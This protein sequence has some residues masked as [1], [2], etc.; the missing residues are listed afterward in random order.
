MI[1]LTDVAE[2]AGVSPATASLALNNSNKVKKETYERV[3]KI[4]KELNYVPNARA[5]ALVKQATKTIGLVIPE[6]INP[7]FA[8]L[9]QAIKNEVKK[10]NYNVILCSTEY[11]FEEEIKYINMF[12]KGQVDGAIFASLGEELSKDNGVI[13]EL[14]DN[15]IPVV[16]IDNGIQNHG[17]I[18]VIKSDLE[19]ASYVAARHLIELGYRDI[20][21]IGKSIKR[22]NGFR[23]AM[24][25]KSLTIN[26]SNIFYNVQDGFKAGNSLLEYNNLPEALI[27]YNDEV[28]IGVIQVLASSGINIPEDISI[29]GIDNIGFSKFYNPPLTTVDIPKEEM[30]EKAA[31]LLLKLIEGREV[32]AEEMSITYSTELIV[33]ESTCQK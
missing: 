16:C 28:A 5:Q 10:E 19:H 18:P 24:E 3:H 4:A 29:C 21:F 31:E 33:R 30:G 2:K 23:K 32:T 7:F 15:Y 6:I 12:K 22:L 25:E 11:K 14:A 8:E 17:V 9:A 13:Q 1:T 20:G 26:D 27:C